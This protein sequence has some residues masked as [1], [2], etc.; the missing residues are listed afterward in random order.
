MATIRES[1][2]TRLQIVSLAVL[3]AIVVGSVFHQVHV[4]DAPFLTRGS[5]ATW[6]G[7]PFV[8]SSG[9]VPVL[10]DDVPPYTFER[11][12]DLAAPP[13][14]ATLRAR[15]LRSLEI[16]VNGS[17]VLWD[18]PLSNWKDS[19]EVDVASKLRPGQ[20]LLRVR[21]RNAS[22]PPLLQLAL[23]GEGLAVETDARWSVSAPGLTTAMATP[24]NDT[25]LFADAYIMPDMA[26]SFANNAL[27]LGVLF[28]VFAGLSAA[29]HK[30]D[31]TAHLARLPDYA[32]VAVTLYWLAVFAF[33]MA[34][35][36]VMMGFDIPAHLAY[37]DYL[38]E[39]RSLPRANE[40]WSTYHPPLFYLLTTGFV[41]L[42]DAVRE[43]AS[44]Q[45]VYRLVSSTAGLS[46]VWATWLC[47]RRF[48]DRDPIKTTGAVLFAGL[49]P[50]N[51]YVSA[52]VSNES[53]L[54]LWSTFAILLAIEAISSER[55]GF[56]Q[57]TSIGA[58]LGLAIATKFSGLILVPVV[59][60]VVATKIALLDDDAVHKRSV[61]GA[62]ALFT[63]LA[64]TAFVGGGWYLRNYL[65][66][67]E[68]VIW[69]VDLPGA[70]AW[71]EHPGFHTAAYYLRFGEVFDHPFYAGFSSFWDGVYSTFWGDGLLAGMVGATTRHP[72][73]N[74]ELM[75]VGYWLVL[76]ASLILAW[77]C[78]ALLVRA[79]RAPTLRGRIAASFVFVVIFAMVF[80][81]MIVTFSVPYYAQAK[82]FYVL[83]AVLPLS[84]AA[85]LGFAHVD[86]RLAAKGAS[87]LRIVFHAWLGTTMTLIVL[88]YLG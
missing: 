6:I 39:N 72:Y 27:L 22:G 13:P 38:I 5:G 68:W 10:R 17:A 52:Y 26:E 56:V 34:K 60:L 46:I 35:L 67:G 37:I 76:P 3:L 63:M 58:A 47:A 87:G 12:F 32:L 73:W 69:N 16:S 15:G 45:V 8:P 86:E 54:A 41:L 44:G 48:F 25:Q 4:S 65:H 42:F 81:L 21:V 23:T 78:V 28:L 30:R 64:T 50:M 51:L 19:F 70:T 77:G 40:S 7:Y 57:W 88:T 20:N 11:S 62:A 43:S 85:G 75:T 80:S 18:A 1:T 36:P 53:L 55:P 29:L 61:R 79:F 82:A 66:F 33:K 14:A 84:L 2:L 9:A 49:V 71:W 24:A 83:G 31:T 74:Y 59:I